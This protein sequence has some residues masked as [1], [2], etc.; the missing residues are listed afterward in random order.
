MLFPDQNGFPARERR[1]QWIV[2]STC[3]TRSTNGWR[4][5]SGKKNLELLQRR[6]A[7]SDRTKNPQQHNMLLRLLAEEDAKEKKTL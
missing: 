5:S 3:T 4:G 6:L 2:S 1:S 7:E